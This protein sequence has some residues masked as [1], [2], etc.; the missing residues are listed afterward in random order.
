VLLTH[1]LV[2]TDVARIVPALVNAITPDVVVEIVRLA[3]ATLHVDARFAL[4][5]TAAVD[6][7][8]PIAT[9][10][11][12]V[13]VLIVVLKLLDTLMATAAPRI[14]APPANRVNPAITHK[15]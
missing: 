5:F 8:L 2:P 4:I 13:P 9:E 12:L 6:D 11:V 15:A 1:E 7:E 14:C 3:A 10:P